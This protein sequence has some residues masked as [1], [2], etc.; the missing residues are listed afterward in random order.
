MVRTDAV[1]G[2]VPLSCQGVFAKTLPIPFENPLRRGARAGM[3]Q[4]E[5]A[6]RAGVCCRCAL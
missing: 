2:K 1:I 4:R 6:R 5:R 3:M